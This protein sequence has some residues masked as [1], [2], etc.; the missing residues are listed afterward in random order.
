MSLYKDFNSK[1]KLGLKKKLDK[2]NIHE[3][4]YLSKVIVSMGIGSLATRK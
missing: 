4:P 2:K 3:V 1:I